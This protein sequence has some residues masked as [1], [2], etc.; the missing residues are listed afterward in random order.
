MPVAVGASA[1][2]GTP[3]LFLLDAPDMDLGNLCH[4]YDFRS[5]GES[6]E[7]KNSPGIATGEGEREAVVGVRMMRGEEGENDSLLMGSGSGCGREDLQRLRPA[8]SFVIALFCSY[9]QGRGAGLLKSD[10]VANK[11]ELVLFCV[12]KVCITERER[13]TYPC[14]TPKLPTSFPF[15]FSRLSVVAVTLS[16]C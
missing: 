7:N 11:V 1:V 5:S 12:S 2:A 4:V 14:S 6:G 13:D 10:R 9:R 16:S 15:P 8:L 3:T